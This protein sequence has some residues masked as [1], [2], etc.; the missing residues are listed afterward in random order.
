MVAAELFA[1][2]TVSAQVGAPPGVAVQVEKYSGSGVVVEPRGMQFRFQDEAGQE[3]VVS[4]APE[5]VFSG[6]RY[7]QIDPLDVRIRGTFE[8]DRLEP[9]M[10]VAFHATMSGRRVVEPVERLTIVTPSADRPP[11]IHD[12]EGLADGAV[13]GLFLGQPLKTPAAEDSSDARGGSGARGRNDRDAPAQKVVIGQVTKA[14][15]LD[16]F[17]VAAGEKIDVG[18]SLQEGALL[19]VD[20]SS[21]ADL[22]AGDPVKLEGAKIAD[23]ALFAV[24][25]EVE[26]AVPP[27]LLER[28]ETATSG[29]P[30]TPVASAPTTPATPGS[31]VKPPAASA[32][33]A[34]SADPKATPAVRGRI[35]EVN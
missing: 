10:F 31:G 21:V 33:K 29:E 13:F 27:E 24:K 16:R 26:R 6:V 3:F 23:N 30:A 8:G 19:F 20:S 35:V 18:A 1:A 14:T 5:R 12:P 11:G 34:E 9:G 32:P 25:V 4:A 28:P 7:G 17:T 22:A 15:G 2:A